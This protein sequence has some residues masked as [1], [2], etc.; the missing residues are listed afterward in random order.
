MSDFYIG[1][2]TRIATFAHKQNKLF[3][4]REIIYVLLPQFADHEIPF[5]SEGITNGEMGPRQEPAYRNKIVAASLDPVTSTSG[6]RVLPDYTFDTMPD[7][8]AAIVLIGGYGW[9]GPEAAKVAPIIRKALQNGTIIGAIC[10]A[11]SW[12]A[13]QGFLNNVSHTGNGLEQLKQWGGDRYTNEAGYQNKQAV[14]DRHIVTA[15]G[16]GHL[17][18]GRELLKLLQNDTDEQTERYY[19]FMKQG[20]VSLFSPKPRFT[21]NTVGLFTTDNAKMVAFYRDIFGFQTAWKG[22][23]NVEMYLGD[24][25]LIFFPRTAFEEMT[26]QHYSYPIGN[27]GTMELAIDVPTFADVDKE[28]ERAV[29]LGGKPVFAP[30]T[31]PW[32]QR[33][34]YIAD[35]EG[36]L[37]EISSF[38][39]S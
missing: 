4:M 31:E 19:H 1:D 11:A 28:Y 37:I 24:M 34:C 25:R 27:N 7:D 21:C 32:G 26:S 33:T 5:L 22:E 16:T 17:E 38:F 20:F 3:I 23:P 6:F 30:T 39:E 15:N 8:Y 35:P 10:N 2:P 14:S 18:F 13:S 29:T 9:Q 12:M 36:N